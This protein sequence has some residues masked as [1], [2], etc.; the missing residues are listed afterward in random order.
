MTAV[1]RPAS[2]IT[3]Q[4]VG[5]SVNDNTT[6]ATGFV[7]PPGLFV[8]ELGSRRPVADS[9]AWQ[10]GT[11]TRAVRHEDLVSETDWS[12]VEHAYGTVP[13]VLRRRKS[14]RRC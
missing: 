2:P 11:H 6:P 1:L 9:C 7:V 14:S 3:A 10:C 4:A 8:G 5:R 12:A 13:G